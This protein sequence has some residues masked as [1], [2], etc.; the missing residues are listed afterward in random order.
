MAQEESPDS[1]APIFDAA[2]LR[3]P[4]VPGDTSE[5]ERAL[6]GLAEK[7]GPM[8]AQVIAAEVEKQRQG[9]LVVTKPAEPGKA[10]EASLAMTPQDR[11]LRDLREFQQDVLEELNNLRTAIENL[12]TSNGR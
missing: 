6:Q 4:I 7:F 12:N 2:V 10:G 3:V 9:M 8:I 5:M 11:F 1:S